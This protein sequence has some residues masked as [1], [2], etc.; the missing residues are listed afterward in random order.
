MLIKIILTVIA[1]ANN[2]YVFFTTKDTATKFSS[3]VKLA[4]D[5]L[6]GGL[7]DFSGGYISSALSTVG[8]ALKD[9][10]PK[11]MKSMELELLD[12]MLAYD[13][14]HNNYIENLSYSDVMT[15]KNIQDAVQD[16]FDY[17]FPKYTKDCLKKIQGWKAAY[18]EQKNFT[19][20]CLALDPNFKP[21]IPT[22]TFWDFASYYVSHK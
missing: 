18:E 19:A 7:D 20:L 9:N 5:L 11:A 3:G 21:T 16:L 22:N 15:D 1:A 2:A 4:G 14:Q 10:L 13:L 17:K 12:A 8:D 6:G